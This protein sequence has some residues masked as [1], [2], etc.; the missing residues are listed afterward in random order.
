MESLG[1]DCILYIVQYL[2]GKSKVSLSLTSW[3]YYEL[4]RYKYLEHINIANWTNCAVC[5]LPFTFKAGYGCLSKHIAIECTD[6]HRFMIHNYCYARNY[7]NKKCREKSCNAYIF[8]ITAIT[9]TQ[10]RDKRKFLIHSGCTKSSAKEYTIINLGNLPVEDSEVY[11]ED[12]ANCKLCGNL[13]DSKASGG[14]TDM[15]YYELFFNPTIY[16]IS[17][18]RGIVETHKVHK[19]KR[20]C[21]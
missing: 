14:I 17:N 13:R 3:Y 9:R 21:L 6:G 8:N 11:N 7:K 20:A 19:S 18:K 16:I 2:D 15:K 1:N 4:V 10:L 12:Y 5:E